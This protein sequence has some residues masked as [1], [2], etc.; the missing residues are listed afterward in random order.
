MTLTEEQVVR[1]SRQIL[2]REVGGHG[3][4]KLLERGV[5]VGALGV[6]IEV[7]ASYLAAGGSPIEWLPP[8]PLG[9]FGRAADASD[10]VTATTAYMELN[11]WGELSAAKVQVV[12]GAGVAFRSETACDECWR[13]TASQLQPG[14]EFDS[15]VVGALGALAAQR[16][17]LGL[18]EP[19]GYFAVLDGQPVSAGRVSC[20]QHQKT[21]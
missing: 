19:L 18:S 12:L 8:K 14:R 13:L 10:F 5:R 15:V 21:L 1:F 11:P 16:L 7:A 2:L 20:S 6:G 9:A 4:L 3:Q 17:V